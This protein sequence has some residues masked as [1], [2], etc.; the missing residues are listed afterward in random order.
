VSSAAAVLAAQQVPALLS[1]AF[2]AV[3]CEQAAEN[4]KEKDDAIY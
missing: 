4:T 2:L 3:L 1:S